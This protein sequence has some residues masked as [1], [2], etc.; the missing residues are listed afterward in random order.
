MCTSWP[1]AWQ[2]LGTVERY[3]TLFSSAMGSASMSA[4]QGHD[5]AR[6]GVALVLAA[7]DVDDQAGALGQDDRA[8]P[9]RGQAQRDAPGGPVLGVADL[10]VGVQVSAELDQLGFVLGDERFQIARQVISFHARLPRDDETVFGKLRDKRIND[11][12]HLAD[13]G[14]NGTL[15]LVR[16]PVFKHF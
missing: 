16:S 11:A 5:P 8:Q 6:G 1:Q 2:T 13:M 14:Q 12:V 7:T 10:G 15:S 3:G 4:A 9:G